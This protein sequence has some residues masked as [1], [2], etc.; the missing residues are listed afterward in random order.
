MEFQG[1]NK[2]YGPRR[3]SRVAPMD[4][5][6]DFEPDSFSNGF[7]RRR[8][9]EVWSVFKGSLFFG[10]NASCIYII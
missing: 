1:N 6:R 5:P 9:E 8:I 4:S 3:R 2:I 7:K 10:E